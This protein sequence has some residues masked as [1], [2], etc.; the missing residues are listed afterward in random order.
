MKKPFAVFLGLALAALCQFALAAPAVVSELTG[1]AQRIPAGAAPITLNKGDSV[2]ERD[3]VQTG[4]NSA[5]VLRFEDGQ[6]SALGADTRMTVN[7]YIYDVKEPAK[8]NVLLS[9]LTGGMRAV[10]GLIGKARP[11]KVAFRAGTATIGIRGTDLTFATSGGD[12][13]VTVVDGSISFTF[14]GGTPIVVTSGNGVLLANGRLTQAGIAAINAAVANVPGLAN[15]LAPLNNPAIINAVT[16]AAQA[17]LVPPG[18]TAPA[19]VTCGASC[20]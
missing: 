4:A 8:S 10:T 2:N 6:I 18:T 19:T 16:I 12:V 20:N 11:D 15:A 17:N 7:A 9:L 5:V 3:T 14:A 1:T 13:V